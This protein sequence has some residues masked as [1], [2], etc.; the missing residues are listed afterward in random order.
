MVAAINRTL[1]LAFAEDPKTI[2]FG[3]DIEDPKGGV[4]GLTFSPDGLCLVTTGG[5]KEA[6]EVKVWDA[7]PWQ[8]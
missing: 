1:Q 7:V 4:F 2:L 8:D 5:E 6:G 3:E